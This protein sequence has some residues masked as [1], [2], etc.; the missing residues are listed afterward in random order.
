MAKTRHLIALS[1]ALIL[2]AACTTTTQETAPVVDPSTSTDVSWIDTEKGS[3]TPEFGEPIVLGSI[4]DDTNNDVVADE[5]TMVIQSNVSA[6]A[7]PFD[8]RETVVSRKIQQ[9]TNDQGKIKEYA[10]SYD[11]ELRGLQTSS[12]STTKAYYD[13]IAG[14]N[15]HLQRGT[16]PGNPILIEKAQIAQAKLDS[17]ATDVTDL[18]VLANDIASNASLASYL[19]EAIRATYGVSGAVDEDHQALTK[20]EDHVNNLNVQTDRQLNE[21]NEDIN[22][23]TSYLSSERRNLQTLSLAIANGELYG[24]SL[25]NRSYFSPASA[26][27]G[28]APAPTAKAPVN[29]SKPLVVIRFDRPNVDFEQAVYLA[30]SQALEK[31]PNVGFE[32]VAVSPAGVNP[33]QAALA[34]TDSQNNAESVLRAMSQMG[35][36]GNRVALS[37]AKSPAARSS[38]VHIFIR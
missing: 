26:L 12:E 15:A 21:V 14:I 18:N 5:E 28:S 20:L 33:A 6:S 29:S 3:H 16:T 2:T 27:P 25:A 1:S 23:R 30:A 7:Q 13:V 11:D 22:R 31:Y 24:Q 17:L 9:L 35:I 10:D 36:P 38:E 8:Y 19:M 32:V 34:T 37:S 4:S